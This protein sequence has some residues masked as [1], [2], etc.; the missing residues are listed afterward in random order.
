VSDNNQW[1]SPGGDNGQPEPQRD[2]QQ[3]ESQ[4][5]PG[6]T[7]AP[8]A[9]NTP[10]APAGSTTPAPAG[11]T[12]PPAPAYAP[13]QAPG[14]WT[15]PPSTGWTAPPQGGQP[16]GT[17][18]A[19]PPQPGLVPLQPM[20]LGTIL[21]GSFQVMRRNPRPT[22]GV[23]L[24]I[25][26]IIAVVSILT[27]FVSSWLGFDRLAMA[28]TASIDEISAGSTA[29]TL[30]STLASAVVSLVGTAILQGIISI[31]VARGTI[32]EKLTFAQLWSRA[33]GRVGVLVGWSLLILVVIG[34]VAGA[35]T[36]LI[37]VLFVSGSAGGA[38]FGALL[39]IVA[40]FGGAVLAAWLTTRLSLVPSVLMIERLAL[41]AAL[42]RSWSLTIGYFWRTFGIQLLVA[43]I[44]GVAAQVVLVP[45]TVG[46]TLVS[47]LGNPNADPAAVE[48]SALLAVVITSVLSALI[49]A[50][51]AIISSATSALIYIDLRIRKEGLDLTLIR[52]VESRQGGDESLPDPYSPVAASPAA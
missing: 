40:V 13:A 41:G 2:P 49:G 50:V 24:I 11:S 31:E 21:A 19:P 46:I 45:V 29:L 44:V 32:G 4:P 8:P 5:Q 18:W 48:N 16:R 10:P 20:T 28:S 36:A 17:G 14:A 9:G 34:V 35:L 30:L 47:T 25:N 3:P 12:P 15:P 26:G 27:V 7:P 43:V 38:V 39:I 51:T 37:V 6:T 1:A 33:K 23:S 22:F 42:R 52:F